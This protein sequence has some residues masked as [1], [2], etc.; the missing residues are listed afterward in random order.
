MRVMFRGDFASM[1][2]PVTEDQFEISDAGIKHVPT[3]CEF[4]PYPGSPHDGT[5]RE[6]YR[7]SKLPDGRDFDVEELD[8][9][10]KRLWLDYVKKRDLKGA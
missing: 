10:M 5:R 6:G 3:G 4:T 8:V 2:T 7:G 1:H 9:M